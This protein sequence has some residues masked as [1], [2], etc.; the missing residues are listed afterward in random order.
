MSFI[1]INVV[2]MALDVDDVTAETT[3]KLVLINYILTAVFTSEVVIK[4][5][6]LGFKN[7]INN[8]WNQYFTP[9]YLMKGSTAA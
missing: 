5:S 8:T 6:I 2:I 9:S 4:I 3:N 7:Y 1:L